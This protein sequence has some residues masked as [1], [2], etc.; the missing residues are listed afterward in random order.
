MSK[1]WKKAA[2]QAALIA[3]GEPCDLRICGAS[4]GFE[5]QAAA[6]E[7]EGGKKLPTFSMTAYTGVPMK[8]EGFYHPVVVDL[9]SASAPRQ[10]VPVPRAH[11]PERILGH[12]TAIDISAQRIKASGI[13]SADNEHSA[14]IVRMAAN[15]FPWQASIGASPKK[16]EFV[17]KGDSV[18]VNGRNWDGPLLVARGATI[19]E[20]SLLPMGADGNTAASVAA[21]FRHGEPDMNFENWLRARSFDPAKIAAQERAV[22]QAA[23]DAEQ[24]LPPSP[25]PVQAAAPAPAQSPPDIKAELSVQLQAA[26]EEAAAEIR[27]QNDL[28]RICAAEPGLETEIEENGQ[29][30]RVAVLEHAIAAGWSAQQ[31]EL[32]VLRATR[33]K[34]P[35]GYVVSQPEVNDRVLEAA[36]LQAGRY[37][38]TDADRSVYSDQV[39][40]AAHSRFRGRI[41]L[42]Q[43]LTAGAALNG[44]R[45]GEVIRDDSDL[46]AVL[47]AAFRPEIRAEG[48]SYASVANLLAN[49]Q[50]KF[51]LAGYMNVESGWRAITAIRPVKDFKPTK[52]VALL[53]DFVYTQVGPDGELKNATITDQA[54]SNQA[55]TYGRIHTITRTMIIND[56]LGAMTTIPMK[57]GR[58]AALKLNKV[59]WSTFMNPG[60]A[61]DGIAFWATTHA[62]ANYFTGAATALQSSSLQTALQMFRNQVDP[63]GEPLGLEPAVLLTPPALEVTAYELLRGANLVYGGG[64]AAKQPSINVWVGRFQPVTSSYLE[65]ASYTGF[66]ATAWYLLGNP[67]DIPV[68]ECCFL[69]GQEQ[70]TVQTAQAEFDTLGIS[71]RGF[72]D[73]GVAMQN[74]RGGVKSKGAA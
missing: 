30:R 66:S 72:F 2:R 55:Q 48:A 58:G 42:Q 35:L 67:N 4:E 18:K 60:N 38:F 63:N 61:D 52:S 11:D 26:R 64:T 33:A 46:R 40:Q 12:T 43:L 22:L 9:E 8:L 36:V 51:L 7:G 24:K 23:Y 71:M 5:V 53:G 17:P 49:V 34:A 16:M 41:G 45:G 1:K 15:G 19:R 62:N 28:R 70:P 44:Y 69:N 68:I 29:K 20:I 37:D 73:F 6:G 3:A 54:F 27:R 47:Q 32:T 57:L 13:L 25:P 10:S 74:F 65:N 21:Q 50:N 59:F 56:D 31:T 14:E 39:Q